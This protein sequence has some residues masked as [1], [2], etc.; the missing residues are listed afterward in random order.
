MHPP[1]ESSTLEALWQRQL[2][3]ERLQKLTNAYSSICR[4]IDAAER[5]KPGEMMLLTWD[6]G[7][8]SFSVAPPVLLPVLRARH[9][10]LRTAI[11]AEMNS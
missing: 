2:A 10:E 6:Y 7:R 3:V 5:Q 4:L 1:T 9:E 8:L 11:E